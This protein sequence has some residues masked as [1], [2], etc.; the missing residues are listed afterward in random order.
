[1][2]NKNY[3]SK[4]LW[5]FLSIITFSCTNVVGQYKETKVNINLQ[6]AT[7]V[8]IFSEITEQTNFNFS[9]GELVIKNKN[10]Y[11]AVYK[12][13]IVKSVLNNL[14]EKANFNYM[15]KGNNIVIYPIVNSSSNKEV[16]INGFVTDEMG[17]PMLGVNIF[18]KNSQVGSYTNLDGE[19]TIT[20]KENSVLEFSFNGYATQE[21]V[22]SNNKKTIEITML[23]ATS[24]L[25]EVVVVGYGVQKK[26]NLTGAIESV[27]IGQFKNNIAPTTTEL[28]QGIAPNVN[29]TMDDGDINGTANINIRGISSINQ[30]SPLVLID[31][32]QGEL[33][34]INPADIATI[35]VLKD[36]A[37]SAIYGARASFGVILVTTKSAISGDVKIS[38]RNNFGWS[39]PTINTDNF[40][41]DGLEWAK[42]SDKLSLIENTSTYLGLSQEDYEYFE[43]RKADPTLP[44]V[45]IKEVNGEARYVHYGNT[46]W[47]NTVFNN[48]QASKDHTISFSGGSDKIKYYLSGRIYER[49]GIYKINKDILDR[50]TLRAKIDFKAKDWLKIGNSTNI[51]F[52]NY[53]SPAT[54]TRNISGTNNSEDWRKYTY[55]ASPIFLPRNPDG[56][57][58][59]KGA[60]TNNRDI[61]DGT[62]AD[63][64]YG[65]SNANEKDFEL[66]NTT[67][68]KVD[69]L[70]GLHLNADY[71][72][73]KRLQN[74]N[75]RIISAPYT[76]QPNGEGVALYKT[77]TQ[78]YKEL[79]R[80]TLYQTINAYLDYTFSPI[81]NHTFGALIGYNQEWNSFKRNIMSRNGNLVENLNSFDLAQGT[82]FSLGSTENEWAI[83]AGFYRFTYNF[84][85]KYLLE[86]NGRF[87]YSSKFPQGKRLGFFPSTSLGW[88]VSKES[89]WKSIKPIL[90]NFKLRGSYGVL[91]N[92]NVSEY[93][94]ISTMSVNQGNYIANN[95][96]T[97][98]FSTPN[99]VSSN[100]TWE[101]SATLDFG[102]DMSMF[103]NKLETTFDWYERNTRDMLTQGEKLPAVFG[104][105]EPNE[106]AADLRTRGFELLVKWRDQFKIGKD[107]FKYNLSLSVGDSKTIITKF[108]NPTNNIES[109]QYYV[110]KELGEI[111]G[112]TVEGFFESDD[113]YL[114]HADQTLVNERITSNYLINHPIA[115]DIK[116]KDINGDGVISSGDRTLEDHGDLKKIGNTNPRY[117]YAINLGGQYKGFDVNVFAQGI[118]KRDWN[119]G[120]DNGFFWGPFSRQYLNF[121]PKSIVDNSWTVDN[122]DAYFPRLAPYAERGGPYTGAQLGVNSDKYLQNAAYLR[123]K[124][125]T[126]GYT[127]PKKIMDK[128]KLDNLRIYATGTNLFTFSPIY[129]HN[130]DKTVDPEQLGDGNAYPFTKTVSLGLEVNF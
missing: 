74:E 88:R 18:V 130:P 68:I 57:L 67:T 126:I 86:M 46:D 97:N 2:N 17:I 112:Y 27:N 72:F 98:Y 58:I 54:N 12:N 25:D 66:F 124:N 9:Y 110:G 19:F 81:K 121:Y 100:Y 128:I 11:S 21:I 105:S 119:P 44:S 94:Y 41:T 35:S 28:L 49:E 51:F 129:K 59:I 122:K 52:K 64:L 99:A 104:A 83:R 85:D 109:S 116:F 127:I 108:N 78:L 101:S 40:I 89:F 32:V 117:N 107:D 125:I 10:K 3:R 45:L 82:N 26:V 93:G 36:A 115:G 106:N 38:Y 7:L 20:T 96:L 87:D 30:G 120:T 92:Q 65:K 111:W 42:L 4:I 16:T 43:A 31:G 79:T 84:S 123:I 48:N 60:Y 69:I 90:N 1:M 118:V 113:E 5:T 77:D 24:E 29:I 102:V 6:S 103:H 53:S 23:Q 114:N 22:V 50:K 63:L 61:A 73:R 13:Q 33:D 70:K 55:H 91:G 39:N 80:S 95:A 62:F 56:S 14:S 75:V 37:A 34:R 47:W 71:S 15:L 8:Q 76:N